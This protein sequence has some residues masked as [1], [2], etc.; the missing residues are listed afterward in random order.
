VR[1]EFLVAHADDL[2][3][4]KKF[5]VDDPAITPALFGR[6]RLWQ[7]PDGRLWPMTYSEQARRPQ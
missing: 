2:R 7:L 3:Q 4:G 6:A 1:Q 5:K